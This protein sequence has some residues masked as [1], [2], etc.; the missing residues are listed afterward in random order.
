MSFRILYGLKE[1][2]IGYMTCNQ[3]C[4][5]GTP[6][7]ETSDGSDI[8]Q[9][10]PC[11]EPTGFITQEVTTDGASYQEIE[12]LKGSLVAEVK[13]D[14]AVEIRDGFGEIATDLVVSS[15]SRAITNASTIYK[16]NELCIFN[17]QWGAAQTG[18]VV[19]GLLMETDYNGVSGDYRIRRLLGGYIKA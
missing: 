6:V 17:G 18:D 5:K 19:S 15:G 8:V 12:L 16:Q 4:S 9:P 14:S 13:V 3:A 10:T 1:I 7:S 11:G 2:N